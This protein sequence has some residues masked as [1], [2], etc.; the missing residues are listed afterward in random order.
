MTHLYGVPEPT[1]KRVKAA[2]DPKFDTYIV[3]SNGLSSIADING[4]PRPVFT[5]QI[6][7]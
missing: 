1:S 7:K 3:L 5:R 4:I 6:C 2:S